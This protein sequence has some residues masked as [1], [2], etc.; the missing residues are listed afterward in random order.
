MKYGIEMRQESK[1]RFNKKMNKLN[2]FTKP[3]KG[4]DELLNT[5]AGDIMVQSNIDVPVDKAALKKSVFIKKKPFN[6]I[7]GYS[8]FYA[9]FVEF[10]TVFQR[11]QPYF[12][13]AIFSA[14]RSLKRNWKSKFRK[15]TRI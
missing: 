5:M 10:G 13:P 7:V 8:V 4:F 15:E 12:R 2:N 1:R 11:A 9:A 14:L 6:L 3:T